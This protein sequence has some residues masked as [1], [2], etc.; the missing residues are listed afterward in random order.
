MDK[1]RIGLFMDDF[2]PSSGG[3]GRSVQ[4]QLAKLTE[5]GHD[6]T[7]FAPNSHFTPPEIGKYVKLPCLRLPGTPSYCCILF[8]NPVL[9]SQMAEQYPL[10]VIH[11]QNERGAYY[12]GAM[13]SK[14]M[15]I[16]QVHTFHTNFAGAHA[17]NPV[18]AGVVSVAYLE[19]LARLLIPALT[20]RKTV[21]LKRNKLSNED[22]TFD[23]PDFRALAR[24]ASHV[25]ECTS[26]ASHIADAIV[27]AS[28]GVLA[29]RMSVIPN[30]VSEPF[31][32]V[33]R[34]RGRDGIT[35]FISV[36][37]LDPEKRVD[38]IIDAYIELA[39]DATELVIIGDGSQFSH[40]KRKA[41]SVRHGRILFTGPLSNQ[42]RIAQE[43]ADADVFV[44]A[45]WHYDVQPMVLI[46][47]AS[48]GTP[49]M[50]CDPRLKTGTSPENALLTNP[51]VAS[52]ARGMAELAADH[53]RLEKMG[54]AGRELSESF[55]PETMAHRY[56]EV[57]RRAIERYVPPK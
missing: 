7:L 24:F 57:Y 34:R 36:G 12:L 52:L 56:E 13:L 4:V 5:A 27:K 38:A 31:R 23:R 14:L 17:D 35:R 6:V 40:L 19:G 44:L 49:I 25:T 10:D 43:V 15:K 26:P 8:A 39:D 33:Q 1:L 41:Q 48:A 54:K 32:K 3:I 50:Y 37:R 22:G 20:A 55:T 16:P 53:G 18:G 21:K 47:A 42:E 45:S 30:G 29:D 9:A 11:T 46:E 51:D 2:F 28:G